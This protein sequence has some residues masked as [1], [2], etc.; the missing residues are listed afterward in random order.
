MSS[1]KKSLNT[2]RKNPNSLLD[3]F[4]IPK[5]KISMQGISGTG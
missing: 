2:K 5:K 4:V 3:D 1:S